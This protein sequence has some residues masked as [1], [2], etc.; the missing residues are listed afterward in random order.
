MIFTNK[1]KSGSCGC[2]TQEVA[3]YMCPSCNKSGSNVDAITIKAQLK[4][5]LRDNMTSG[6]DEFNF[7]TNPK[8]DTVY[9]ANDSSEIFSQ[10]DIKSKITI[11]NDDPKTPLCY[12]KKLLKEDVIEMIENKEENIP[13]KIKTII[14]QGKSFCKKSNPKGTCCTEDITS[15]LKEYGIDFNEKKKMTFSLSPNPLTSSCC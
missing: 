13:G 3:T 14:S 1:I 10:S 12:C 6:L 15:F 2:A 5:E 11:K 8:C 7:C 9:Y 4:K